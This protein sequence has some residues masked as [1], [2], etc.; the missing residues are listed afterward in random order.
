MEYLP[1]GL[2]DSYRE[3]REKTFPASASISRGLVFSLLFRVRGLRDPHTEHSVV[4]RFRVAV[5]FWT[6]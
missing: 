4:S 6:T 3:R 2:P 5:Q 1:A